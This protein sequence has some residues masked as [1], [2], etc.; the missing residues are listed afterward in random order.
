MFE[1]NWKMV[2]RIDS[3]LRSVIAI[4]QDDLISYYRSIIRR[5]VAKHF[6]YVGGVGR[7]I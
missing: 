4:N 3:L 5:L 7:G 6:V 1:S 2:T